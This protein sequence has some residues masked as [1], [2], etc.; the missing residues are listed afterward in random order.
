LNL[1]DYILIFLDQSYCQNQTNSQ[2]TYCKRGT[3]N[4]IYQTPNK[5]G[6]SAVGVQ[7][8]NGNSLISFPENTRTFEMMKYMIQL[9]ITNISNSELAMN[10]KEIIYNEELFIENILETVNKKGNYEIVY[11]TLEKSSK[12][13]KTIDKLSNRFKKN[14]Y[15]FKTRSKTVLE[16]LQKTM[17]LPYFSDKELQHSLIIEKPL[18]VILDNYKVHHAIVFTE[19]CEKLN[20]DLIYLPPYSPKY[21]PIEQVWRTIKAEISRRNLTSLDD[22]INEFKNEYY[23]IVD[24]P[25]FWKKWLYEYITRFVKILMSLTRFSTNIFQNQVF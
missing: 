2:K 22:L 12:Q 11:E 8:V 4:I 19:L 16:Y 21:Y 3:K 24:R 7:A 15:E 5:M 1:I 14:K 23:E 20:I 9:V 13:N 17:L 25:S 18:A 6:I 10:L